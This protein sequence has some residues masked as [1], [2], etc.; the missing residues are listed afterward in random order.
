GGTAVSCNRRHSSTSTRS[1]STALA[2]LP[3]TYW[4]SSLMAARL[5]LLANISST[6]AISFRSSSVT[7]LSSALRSCAVFRPNAFPPPPLLP[8]ANRPLASRPS[9]ACRVTVLSSTAQGGLMGPLPVRSMEWVRG[10]GGRPEGGGCLP[11]LCH[12]PARH[13]QISFPL[14]SAFQRPRSALLKRGRRSARLGRQVTEEN[15]S[16]S[17]GRSCLAWFLGLPR[18]PRGS[19]WPPSAVLTSLPLPPGGRSRRLSIGP[20]DL[21]TSACRTSLD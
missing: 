13:G 8:V 7:K 16:P 19:H 17:A 21:S 9:L 10:A 11:R 3:S 1:G 12:T 15:Q 20:V 6:K 5:P 2:G 14:F 4:K 18:V